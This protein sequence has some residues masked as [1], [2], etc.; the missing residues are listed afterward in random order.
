[1]RSTCRSTATRIDAGDHDLAYVEITLVDADGNVHHLQDRPVTV[2]VEG[3]AVLQ[4]FG[5]GNPCTEETFGA[6]THDTYH[7][8]ALAVLRPTGAGR[9]PSR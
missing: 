8:R 4:G 5:S 1:M 3:P 9:S 2:T 7:G 6:P